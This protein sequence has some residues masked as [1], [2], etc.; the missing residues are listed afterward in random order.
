MDL[1][2]Q[3]PIATK[4]SKIDITLEKNT[5]SIS[6]KLFKYLFKGDVICLKGEIGVGKTTFIKYLINNLQS[7][8]KIK[9]TAYNIDTKENKIINGSII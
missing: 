5:K 9:E 4:S 7:K 8:Y 1:T 2:N 6:Q 3:M